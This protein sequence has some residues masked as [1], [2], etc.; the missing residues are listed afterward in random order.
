MI[1][2]RRTILTG[3]LLAGG[4]LS[5]A[6]ALGG[7]ATASPAP[8]GWTIQTSPNTG[9]ANNNSLVAT[10][11]VSSTFCVAVGTAQP[12]VTYHPLIEMWNG[13]SW[14]IATVPAVVGATEQMLNGVSCPTTTFCMATGDVT[15]G[16][17]GKPLAEEWN[18]ATWAIVTIPATSAPDADVLNGVSCPTTAF[19]MTTGYYNNGSTNQTMSETWNGTAWS[20]VTIP[21]ASSFSNQLF[22]VSCSSHSFCVTVGHYQSGSGN[23]PLI[24][25]WNVSMWTITPVPSTSPANVDIL[26][27]VSCTSTLFCM[28]VGMTQTGSGNLVLTDSWNGSSWSIVPSAVIPAAETGALYAVSC[29]GPS[30]CAAAGAFHPSSNQVLALSWN[31]ATWTIPTT[32]TTTAGVSSQNQGISCV[33]DVSC[34]LVATQAGTTNNQTEILNAPISRTGYYLVASDGGIFT[35]G[36]AIFYGSTGS[37]H[38]NKPIVGMAE[39]PDGGGYWLVASDGGI[40]AFGDAGYFGS[41]GATPLNKPIVGM[42]ATPD[43][44]GYWLVASD[45]GI[46]AFGNAGFFGSEGA[47]PLNKPIVGMAATPDGFGYF[48]VASDGGIF[49]HGD[50]VFHGSEGATPLNKPIV[51]MAATPD[52]GGY[53]LV[54]SD[55]GIFTHGD[56]VFAGSQGAVILN[57]PMVG[58]AT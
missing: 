43:G 46:F 36:G 54:A 53:F 32:P 35:H 4:M 18:G 47:T 26:E 45:G 9:T 40:F 56:A 55:G 8:T 27:G 22:A 38:L 29:L 2:L 5:G 41:M 30:S 49:T 15:V 6:L 20:L 16:G 23:L 37:L 44:G 31:G 12:P 57:K 51:G 10:S 34:T 11:C 7:T 48:L 13:V 28:A 3:G 50:A 39:T 42:A 25:T 33:A 24:E 58:M 1:R 19:C 21:S 17:L 14:T 52:G